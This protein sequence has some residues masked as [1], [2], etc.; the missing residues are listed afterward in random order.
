MVLTLRVSFCHLTCSTQVSALEFI[1]DTYIIH[2]FAII[3]LLDVTPYFQ[4]AARDVKPYG[5]WY[6]TYTHSGAAKTSE[7]LLPLNLDCKSY[8]TNFTIIRCHRALVILK[9]SGIV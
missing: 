1:L 8:L 9:V 2:K 5:R 6:A 3:S 7:M 4:L